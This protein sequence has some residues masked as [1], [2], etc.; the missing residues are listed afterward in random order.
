MTK[1]IEIALTNLFMAV[2][3]NERL[4]ELKEKTGENQQLLF[5]EPKM[6]NASIILNCLTNYS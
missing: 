1:G 2:E 6:A 4:F 5:E 3:T